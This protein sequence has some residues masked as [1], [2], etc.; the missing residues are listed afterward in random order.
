MAVK[1]NEADTEE[2]TTETTNTADK[3]VKVE[4]AANTDAEK[5]KK[6][7]MYIGPQLPSGLLKTN[8]IIKGTDKEITEGLKEVFEKFP[9]VKRMLVPIEDVATKKIEV[10]TKGKVLNKYYMDIQSQIAANGMKEG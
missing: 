9:L 7:V 1:K 2:K 6:T 8:T 10:A 4:N 3:T 5:G